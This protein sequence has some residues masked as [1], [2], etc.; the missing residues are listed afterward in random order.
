MTRQIEALIAGAYMAGTNTKRVKRAL[1]ALFR[2]TAGEDV[3]SW[4]WRKVRT[5]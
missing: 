2:G 1:S 3:V 5:D 4:T